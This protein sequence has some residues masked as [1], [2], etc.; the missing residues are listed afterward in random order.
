MTPLLKNIAQVKELVEDLRLSHRQLWFE[1]NK[2]FGWEIL[3]IR[4]GGILSRIDTTVWRL[5][6]WLTDNEPIEELAETKLPFDGPYLMP[7]GIIGRNLYHG[8]ISPSKLSDV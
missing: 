7:K 6:E 8:I 5:T 3:D 4:Y 2:P 1:A